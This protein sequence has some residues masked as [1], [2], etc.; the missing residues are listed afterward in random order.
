MTRRMERLMQARLDREES[1]EKVA[2][3][4]RNALCDLMDAEGG[5]PPENNPEGQE[6]WNRAE[7]ALAAYRIWKAN[8]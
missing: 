1:L 7:K 5:E 8:N 6:A 3:N 4:L 2:K